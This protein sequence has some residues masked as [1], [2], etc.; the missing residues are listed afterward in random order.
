MAEMVNMEVYLL[1]LPGCLGLRVSC[2]QQFSVV[3]R[4]GISI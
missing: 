2:G 3:P 4:L 1:R